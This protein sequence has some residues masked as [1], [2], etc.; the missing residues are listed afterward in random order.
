ML[1]TERTNKILTVLTILFT[2]SI[3]VTVLGTFYGMNVNLPLRD[4]NF[5]G[6]YTT[7]IVVLAISIAMALLMLWYFRRL[8]WIGV[9]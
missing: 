4:W 3:P 8:G 2:L 1:N 7:M 5:F 6:T 9:S